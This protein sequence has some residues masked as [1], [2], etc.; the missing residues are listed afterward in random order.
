MTK[1]L[2][3]KKIDPEFNYV[4]Q[5]NPALEDWRE[6]AAAW[7]KDQQRGRSKKMRSLDKFLLHYLHKMNLERNPYNFL[8]KSYRAP[9]FWDRLALNTTTGIDYTNHIHLSQLGVGGKAL[10]GG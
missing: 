6:L 1:K 2:P 9:C 10:G 7:F 3:G 4:C 5:I 8:R